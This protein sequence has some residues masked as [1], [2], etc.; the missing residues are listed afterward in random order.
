MRNA[1]SKAVLPLVFVLLVLSIAS[2][3]QSL[4][5]KCIELFSTET[6]TRDMATLRNDPSPT[7]RLWTATFSAA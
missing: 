5:C 3:S 2:Y 7:T 1:F 4:R 6:D